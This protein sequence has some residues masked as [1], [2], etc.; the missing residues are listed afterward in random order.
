MS[1]DRFDYWHQV[2]CQTIV[3]HHSIPQC[4]ENFGADINVGSL[5]ELPLVVFETSSMSV[6]RTAQHI[7][8]A[9]HDDIFGCLQD[10]A[11]SC[12]SRKAAKPGCS[13]AT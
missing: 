6:F 12:W 5:A 3:D 7:R 10:P 8:R 11:N 1:A 4:R 13:L 2:A 9:R